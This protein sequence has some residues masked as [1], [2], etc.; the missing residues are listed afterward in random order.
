LVNTVPNATSGIA[1]NTIRRPES[2]ARPKDPPPA[3]EET[4]LPA[5]AQPGRQLTSTYGGGERTFVSQPG[6]VSTSIFGGGERNSF[7]QPGH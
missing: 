7:S 4:K 1:G 2:P 6:H 5:V 3:E